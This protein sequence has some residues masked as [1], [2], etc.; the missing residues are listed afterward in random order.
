M[1]HRRGFLKSVSAALLAVT[2]RQ[3]LAAEAE[4]D[5]RI[6]QLIDAHRPSRLASL[7]KDLPDRIGATHVD[8]KYH[9]TD[10]PFLIEGAEKLLELGTRV[11]KFWFIPHSV[12][13]DYRFNS[14][15]PKCKTLVEL[16]RTEYFEQLFALPFLTIILEAHGNSDDGWKADHSERFYEAVTNEFYELALHLFKK[17]AERKVTFVLQHW[18]GDWL[19]RGRGGEKWDPPPA[20][21]QKL[22]EQMQKW[23][24]ARQ[25]GVTKARQEMAGRCK[26]QIYH[27]AEV[28]RVTDAWKEIPTMVRH[29]LPRVELDMVSYS[30]YDALRDPL[31]LWR[32][33][34]EIKKQARRTSASPKDNVYIGEIGIPENEQP[35]RIREKWDDWLAVALAFQVPYVV[36]WELYCNELN[37]KL[38]PAP[39]LPV[40]ASN[41]VRGFWL[42][43]P[44]GS[45]SQSGQYFKELW[46]RK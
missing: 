23:L 30:S 39:K 42:V 41:E 25:S 36:Q 13:R 10:K 34:T 37:P 17:F 32:C 44:D 12:L 16:A 40:K 46:G 21:W 4:E 22:C 6:S 29:V 7:P 20:N 19:L 24:A 33:L 1:I 11:G 9:L 2:P 27:A 38:R 45:L 26:C 5:A 15:W 35:N 43:R 3:L 14:Q 31:T 8:G 18:E 28:N